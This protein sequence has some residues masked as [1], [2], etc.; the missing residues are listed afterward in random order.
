MG[1]FLCNYR[2][3]PVQLWGSSCAAETQEALLVK[4][5]TKQ[6]SAIT[7]ITI[8][9]PRAVVYTASPGVISSY[10]ICK[11]MIKI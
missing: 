2:G 8:M 7:I 11:C 1:V 9:S 3:G 5:L 6:Q 10:M 4:G